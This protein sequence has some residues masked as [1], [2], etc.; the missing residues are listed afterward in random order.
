MRLLKI[1]VVALL[2][3]LATLIGTWLGL[4]HYFSR[5]QPAVTRAEAQASLSAAIGW[6]KAHEADVLNDGN[7]ALWRMVHKS[8]ELTHDAYL[9]QLYNTYFE[10]YYGHGHAD[11]WEH[12]LRADSSAPLTLDALN[13]L[14]PYQRFFIYASTCNAALLQ[15]DDVARQLNADLCAPALPRTLRGQ[16]DATCSTHQLMA[17]FMMQ[18]RHCGDAQATQATIASTQA[19]I[20]TA[21]RYDPRARDPYIQRVL[22]LYETGAGQTV[23]PVWLRRVIDTQLPDGGWPGQRSVKLLFGDFAKSIGL[24]RTSLSNEEGGAEFHATAQGLLLMSLVVSDLSRP[25]AP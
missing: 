1:L 23:R 22:M 2:V 24:P 7:Q 3:S 4:A 11:M 12:W 18:E 13:I 21:L 5:Q 14:E 9:N 15:D 8:A 19:D 20:A 25:A 6:L 16:K 17:L 10:R